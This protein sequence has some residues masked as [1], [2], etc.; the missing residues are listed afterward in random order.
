MVIFSGPVVSTLEQL[1]F[2]F[3]TQGDSNFWETHTEKP[4]QKI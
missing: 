3:Y 1:R 2:Q 4:D